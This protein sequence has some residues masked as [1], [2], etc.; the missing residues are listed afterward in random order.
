MLAGL[1]WLWFVVRD[2]GGPA[3]AVAIALPVL[4][5]GAFGVA[6]VVSLSAWRPRYLIP[7][8]SALLVA[9]VATVAPRLPQ[10]TPSPSPM[11]RVASANVFGQNLQRESAAETLAGQGADVIGAVEMGGRFWLHLTLAASTRYPYWVHPHSHQEE[12]G[13]RSRWPLTELPPPESLAHDPILR[14][15]VHGP[16]EFVLYLVH[17]LNPLH[18]TS[19]SQQQAFTQRLIAAAAQED[20]PVVMMGDFNMSDRSSSYRVMDG[21]MRDALRAGSF[22]RSTYHGT[23][24]RALFLRIDHI[25]IPSEWCAA[26]GADFEVPGSDHRGVVADVGPCT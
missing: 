23:L 14:V 11:I 6:V 25:F 16:T 21:S 26:G 17:A 3:D 22:A 1:P 12:L 24:W 2:A 10:T 7:G 4:G 15:D 5:F 18:E 20:L 13:L 8:L 9:T 19:F